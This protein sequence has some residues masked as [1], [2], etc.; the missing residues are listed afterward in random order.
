MPDPTLQTTA[1][2]YAAADLPLASE[3]SY[4]VDQRKI[5][6]YG[7]RFDPVPWPVVHAP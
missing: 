6:F 4:W 2:R 7:R 1:L 5:E 3:E